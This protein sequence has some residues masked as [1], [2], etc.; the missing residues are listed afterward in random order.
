MAFPDEA[1]WLDPACIALGVASLALYARYPLP[2]WSL[3]RMAEH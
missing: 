1:W 3:W 2:N